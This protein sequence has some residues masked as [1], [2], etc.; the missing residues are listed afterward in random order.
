MIDDA[1]GYGDGGGTMP[2]RLWPAQCK[3]LWTLMG[4]R[5]VLILKARQLGISWLCCS[6]ALWLCLFHPGKV[7]LLFSQGEMEAVELL[8][9]IKALYDRLPA[10]L[11][12]KLPELERDNTTELKWA[13]GSHARSLPAS[14]KAGRSLT[15]SLAILDEAAF[16]QWG[17][18]L[19]TAM[20]PTIDGGGQLVVLSTA[21]GIGNL[22]HRLWTK[23]VQGLNSFKTEFLAWWER[24]GRDSLWYAARVAEATDPNLVKQEYPATATEAFLVSGRT[25][26]ASEWIE[27]Q[28]ANVRPG[29]PRSEWPEALRWMDGLTVYVL[30]TG[31]SSVIGADVAE[32]LE[33]GDF[34]DGA[35]LDRDTWEELAVLHGHWEPDE[36][37]RRLNALSEV[38]EAMIAVERN[39]HGHAVL[40]MLRSLGCPRIGIGH[41]DRQGWL[42]NVQ[43]KPQS[44]DIL[45]TALRD[46][47]IVIHTEA[48]LD[49]LRIYRVMADGKTGAP[50]GYHDDRVM[51]RAIGLAYIQWAAEPEPA[52]AGGALPILAGAP[53][54]RE[55]HRANGLTIP[56]G[57]G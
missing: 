29:L 44:I 48:A 53:F 35:L 31:R 28:A 9:R 55:Y 56:G 40:S 41:D 4:E 57:L 13:N 26:F 25:R 3:L 42:S 36:F 1:Q 51:S 33:H 50:E 54:G 18:R 14:Q 49:E 46:E 38:Y 24:P 32:G 39:N 22:F 27:A 30:P 37:A 10:W 6:Y 7:V 45:A 16:L 8:R 34:S 43:T 15:A 52:Q 5:L 20:K 19:Y 11:R 17:D 21:N 47:L 12:A 23:A 2:F